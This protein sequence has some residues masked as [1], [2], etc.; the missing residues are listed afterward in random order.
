MPRKR[1][2]GHGF[3][4]APVFL[5]SISTILGAILFLRFGYAVAHVGL[6]GT[7]GIIGL[8]HLVT[9]PT[10]LAV[11]EIAT[12]RRVAGGGAYYI[13]SRSFG[14]RIGG[15]I[16]ISLFLSQAISVAFYLVAFAEAFA[17]VYEAVQSAWGIAVD[18]RLAGLAALALLVAL[19]L[20]RGASLGVRAL[21][22]VSAVL[23]G[24]ILSFLLGEAPEAIRPE[25]LN[26][27]ATIEN[28]DSFAVV[29]AIVFPAF[30]GMIAGLG[31][32]GDLRDPGRSIPLGTITATLA[33]MAIYTLVAVKLAGSA[34]PEALA[35]DQFVMADIALWGPSIHI[36]LGAAALSSALGALLVA[37]RTLQALAEDNLLPVPLLNR[38]VE[39]GVG[40][41]NEPRAATIAT[42]AL[43]LFFVLLGGVDF[44]AAILTMFFL[45]TYG[46]L[47]SVAFLEYFA[48]NPSY[49]PTFRTRWYISL[50]G[51]VMCILLMVR[52]NPALAVIAL[53]LLV[54]FYYGLRN[55]G[56]ERDFASIFQ[57]A[58]FQLTRWLQITLQKNRE[59]GALAGF[60]PS[61][62]AVT[63]Y[64]ERLGHFDLLRWISHRH[65]FGHFVQYFEGDYSRDLD[66]RA[67]RQVRTLIKLTETARAGVFVDSVISPTFELALAH[68]LQTPGISGLPNNCVLLELAHGREA[69]EAA[70]TLRGAR[71]A[72]EAGFHTLVLR[73]SRHRFGYRRSIDLWLTEETFE[74][75]RLM[76]LLAYII[77]GHP[78]WKRAEIRLFACLEG[79]SGEAGGKRLSG[80]LSEERLPIAPQNVTLLREAGSEALGGLVSAYSA[81]ADLLITGLSATG[82]GEE[83][84]LSRFPGEQDLLFVHARGRVSAASPEE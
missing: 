47:C 66:R 38:V 50:V 41:A 24:A 36:G 11:S 45:V 71:R 74:N 6:W 26:L 12:N 57:G 79:A 25:G 68:T 30:T 18:P 40:E 84:A 39:K 73:S 4:A 54:V 17:P 75:A 46:A 9:I 22:L 55:V 32:S 5:A 49:R 56:G 72:S 34:T 78:E 31:L 13:I 61:V 82:L 53:L 20:T 81:R 77:V 60:R 7:L 37:P 52:M 33:G 65:G 2:A 83:D 58:M 28:P 80:L 59:S 29:F 51:A 43:A 67:R 48:G 76:L 62:L 14:A 23:M 44:I 70:E 1:G 21:W 19:M 27:I 35:A 42:S 10:V 8:A 64:G 63:R 16:G 3:G 15:V 69:E